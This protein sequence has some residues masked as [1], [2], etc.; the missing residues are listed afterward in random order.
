MAWAIVIIIAVWLIVKNAKDRP[1][2]QTFEVFP[3]E[4][5]DINEEDLLKSQ[6]RF[7]KELVEHVDFPDGIRFRDSYLYKHLMRDW[8]A[9]LSGKHRYDDKII[10]KLRSD[11][12]GYMWALERGHTNHYLA[13]E[14]YGENQEAHDRY[15]EEA[16]TYARKAMA[17]EDGFASAIGEEAVK[18]LDR[19]RNQGFDKFSREGEI[20]PE[21]MLWDID[22]KLKKKRKTD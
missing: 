2:N 17:I 1:S 3:T 8:F 5:K 7:E 15:E 19:I 14:S 9:K 4:N 10:Q 11:W 13:M 6:T 21:G 18:E 22:G 20:A 12:L 16:T